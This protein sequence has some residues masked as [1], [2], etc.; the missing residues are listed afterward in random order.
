[1]KIRGHKARRG[2]LDHG[3][4][5]ASLQEIIEEFS[6]LLGHVRHRGAQVRERA[7]SMPFFE[8]AEV[9]AILGGG[10]DPGVTAGVHAVKRALAGDGMMPQHID[11]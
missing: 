5:A 8:A 10:N 2:A 4:Y 6:L 9:G 3:L 11:L 1:M 7:L